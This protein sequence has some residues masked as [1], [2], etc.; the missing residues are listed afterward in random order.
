M[1]ICYA[2]LLLFLV[3]QV[4]LAQ[5]KRP[6]G[7]DANQ[8]KSA[9]K[10]VPDLVGL[11][12][13]NPDVIRSNTPITAII[14][15]VETKKVPTSGPITVYMLKDTSFVHFKFN[16]TAT[17]I[18]NSSVQNADWSFDDTTNPHFY[19]FKSTKAIAGG[20]MSTIGLT[21]LFTTTISGRSGISVTI[22]KGS[23]GEVNNLNNS[24]STTINYSPQ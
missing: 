3:S 6:I 20:K 23:G 19:I 18:D 9:K 11:I 5:T 24:G 16:P 15:V 22:L 21:G 12:T 17:S 1:K 7:K 4:S 10:P 14:D 13:I 2:V 8:K